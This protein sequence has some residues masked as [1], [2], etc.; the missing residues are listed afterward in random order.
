MSLNRLI[1]IP[2]A[3]QEE[4]RKLARIL[5]EEDLASCV[6]LIPGVES[7]YRYKGVLEE[8]KEIVM[9]VKTMEEKVEDLLKRVKEL[10]S[11]ESPVALIIEVEEGLGE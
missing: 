7:I 3:T 10:H 6:N 9:M 5:V 2:I 4:A 1:Y 8:A 11:Y